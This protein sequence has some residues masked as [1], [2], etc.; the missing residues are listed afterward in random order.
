MAENSKIQ[1]TTNTFNPWRGCT[2]GGDWNEWP[3]DLRMRE[4]PT[5]GAV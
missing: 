2:K 3:E 4:F 1:W 5:G